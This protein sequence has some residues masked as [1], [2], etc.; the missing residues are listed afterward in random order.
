MINFTEHTKIQTVY[1]FFLVD[2]FWKKCKKSHF[3]TRDQY[4]HL[5][6]KD[7]NT[8][9]H[10][11]ILIYKTGGSFGKSPCPLPK[12]QVWLVLKKQI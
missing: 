9:D 11:K 2:P 6:N 1:D 5:V 4:W 10:M 3:G 7:F 8:Y 12:L